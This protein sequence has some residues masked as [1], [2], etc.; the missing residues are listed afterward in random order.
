M[1]NRPGY[2]LSGL[3][4]GCLLLLHS[5]Q[6]HSQSIIPPYRDTVTA[7]YTP[8]TGGMP[9]GTDLFLAKLRKDPAF[10][11]KEKA[12][13][14]AIL[15]RGLMAKA[16]RSMLADYTLPVVFHIINANP[17][18]ITDA[19]VLSAL[20]A[21]NEAFSAS[22]AFTGGR[23]DTRIQFCLAKTDPNGG[24]TSGILRNKTYLGDY[25]FDMEGSDVTALGR[26]DPSRYVNIWVVE[27]IKS[28]YMQTF[29]CGVWTRL[30]MGGYASAGGDIVVAGLG[31]GV[32]CHETGHYLSL[33]HTFANQD[34]ANTDCNTSGDMV[35]D[36]PPERTITGGYPCGS[37][38]NSCSSDTLSGFATDVPDLPDNF[39]DYGNGV[40]C[41]LSFTEGQADRM[42][43]FIASS[44]TGMIAST[45][46]TAPCTDP[47]TASFTPDIDFPVIGDM[48]HLT[49]TSTGASSYEWLVDGVVMA[50]STNF[51]YT[52]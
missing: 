26:W 45:V 1:N 52:V 29:E 35:C 46:C 13:N 12:M 39:M 40:G 47:L 48:L 31:T 43:N 22:G 41:I 11:S 33:L 51:T 16:S 14:A 36:T 21:M 5:L 25:D 34:C 20:Q 3:L 38:P 32:L 8:V 49:N 18:S 19:A 37:P 24:L 7:G 28:E 44:L 15:Q 9:C 50:T 23:T 4:L 2:P 30:K 42:R 17:S 27:D 6:M 10:L